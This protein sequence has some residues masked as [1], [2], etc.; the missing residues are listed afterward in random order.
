MSS[1]AS[2]TNNGTL[3][4]YTSTTGTSVH[5][6]QIWQT[7]A[8]VTATFTNGSTGNLLFSGYEQPTVFGGGNTG[9]T[10]YGKFDNA[11]TTTITTSSAA[12]ALGLF[13][14]SNLPN[15]FTNSGTLNISATYR[16]IVLNAKTYN[17]SF[18]NTGTLNI[19]KGYIFSAGASASDYNTIDNN[20]PGKINFNYGVPAGT[21][22]ATSAAIINNNSGST[23]NGSCTFAAST[24]VTNSG[25]TLS[26]GDYNAGV[27]GIGKMIITP[28]SAAFTL[29]GNVN[30][31]VNG[32]TTAGTD[33]DQIA[34]GS[35]CALALSGSPV[36]NLTVGY[37]PS[38]TD[39]ISVISSNTLSG[40]LGSPS[41]PTGWATDYASTD[42]GV[43]Y[44]KTAPG[45]PAT[46]TATAGNTRASV[47][48]TTPVSD[49]GATITSYTVS[50]NPGGLTASGATSP[51]TVNGLTN[52]QTYTFTVTATNSVGTG[53]GTTSSPVTPD[54]TAN[55]INVST[56]TT[57][58][59]GSLNL[60]PVSDVVVDNAKLLTINS[61]TIINS[62]TIA[63]GGQ[64]T[65][66]SSLTASS[67]TINSDGT[68]GT[69]T[70]ND[71]GGT[72][73]VT[74]ATVKQYLNSSRN[75][76][77]SSPVSGATT[78]ANYTFYSYHES[79]DNTGFATQSGSPSLYWESLIQGTTLE[80]GRGYIALPTSAATLNF[81]GSLNTG[82]VTTGSL[83]RT[84][85]KTKEG[86]NLIGNPY[87]A[88]LNLM[89]LGNRMDTTNVL[90]SYWM[91]TRN[92]A[93]NAYDFDTFNL[94]SGLG[95]SKSGKTVNAVIPPMQ[96]FWVRVKIGKSPATLTFT[97]AMCQHNNDASNLFRAPSASQITQQVLHLQVSNGV[98]MDETILAFNPNASNGSDAYDSPKMAINTVTIPEI[99]TVVEGE[100]IA[101]NGMN[102][103]PYDTE[104]PLGF[105]T[106]QSN[107]FSMKASQF[108]N[109]DAGTKIILKDYLDLN[110]PVITDLSDGNSYSFTSI[111]TSNNTSRFTLTFK[112]PS[113][114]TGINPENNGNVWI[115]T[116][117]GQIV[118]N[119]TASNRVT[120]EI[121]NAVG[122]KVISRNFTGTNVQGNNNLTTGVYLVKLT[123]EGKS[124]TKKII[125]D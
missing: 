83:T 4:I 73:S 77:M 26:P 50:S 68:N 70:Y 31:Q 91:R 47:A 57:T 43:K 92:L 21:T 75:W 53:S 98:N 95:I 113:V 66:T 49:G 89:A 125:I 19:T 104:I 67:L 62:L 29:A 106:G 60:T 28:A 61:T 27:S 30:V 24:L 15:V 1:S 38:Y 102:S 85:G 87:P 18:S 12:G 72:T 13:S 32:K 55:N 11:G 63:G 33:Y 34:F 122:Q 124:I 39:R 44:P 80:N 93:D 121:F 109:F 108:S 45:A 78:P 115:S 10:G 84:T 3:N 110:S 36:I 69:G 86:F 100:Q 25:S 9:S 88:Y 41:L 65:N 64:V 6:L 40:F 105:T 74:S 46:V 17:G 101:I 79:G 112:A 117:N 7:G 59:G 14:L 35:T 123:N 76:Y 54:A 23:I 111:V 114:S 82:S 119:G 90:A 8:G 120:L 5:A 16:A 22:T 2:V 103:I 58:S 42:V 81:S 107:T 71:Y 48:F 97:K 20:S 99:Y 37:T 94:M 51:L 52:T 116:L 56:S 118:V 96:A